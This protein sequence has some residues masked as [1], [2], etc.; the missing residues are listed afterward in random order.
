MQNQYITNNIP[1]K[2]NGQELLGCGEVKHVMPPVSYGWRIE[3]S[4]KVIGC[5]IPFPIKNADRYAVSRI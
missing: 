1:G 4:L 3:V 2:V 5:L